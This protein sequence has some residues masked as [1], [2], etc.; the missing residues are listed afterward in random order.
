MFADVLH[1][2]ITIGLQVLEKFVQ[3]FLSLGEGGSER[4][5]PKNVVSQIESIIDG[6]IAVIQL[7][8]GDY[9]IGLAETGYIKGF[10]GSKSR[11]C[12]V[13]SIFRN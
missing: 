5:H 7:L 10:A 2:E 4:C 3:P 9:H 1:C 8:I 12:M 11:D 13:H 6:I